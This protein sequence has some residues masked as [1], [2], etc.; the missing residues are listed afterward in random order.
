MEVSGQDDFLLTDSPRIPAII[1]LVDFLNLS[2]KNIP[3]ST[4]SQAGNCQPNKY[5]NVKSITIYA[6]AA[7]SIFSS[8]QSFLAS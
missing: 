7:F 5:Q 3:E 4:H 6:I 1:R 2:A 8:F